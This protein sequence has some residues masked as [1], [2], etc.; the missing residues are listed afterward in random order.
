ML[1]KKLYKNKLIY[2]LIDIAN[3]RIQNTIKS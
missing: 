3:R 2:T 1:E